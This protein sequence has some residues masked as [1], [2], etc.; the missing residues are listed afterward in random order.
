MPSS[1]SNDLG[2]REQAPFKFDLAELPQD[3]SVHRSHFSSLA[4]NHSAGSV[5]GTG[6]GNGVSS[7]NALSPLPVQA[8]SQ[9]PFTVLHHQRAGSQTGKTNPWPKDEIQVIGL[10]H[11]RPTKQLLNM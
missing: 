11:Q 2:Q 7:R 6:N 3:L 1:S 5:H 4:G 9:S 10:I 8:H